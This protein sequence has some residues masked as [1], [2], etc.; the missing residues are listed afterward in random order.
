[1]SRD[2]AGVESRNPSASHRGIRSGRYVGSNGRFI[3]DRLAPRGAENVG[4]AD[5][6]GTIGA[7]SFSLGRIAAF[8]FFFFAPRLS[9]SIADD[10]PRG[11]I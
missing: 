2:E 5:I 11:R 1:M 3:V 4:H 6:F 8:L 10:K 7:R 9:H